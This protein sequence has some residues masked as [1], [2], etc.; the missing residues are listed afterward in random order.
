MEKN[1]QETPKTKRTKSV[2]GFLYEILNSS[3]EIGFVPG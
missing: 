2:I 1:E 3:S